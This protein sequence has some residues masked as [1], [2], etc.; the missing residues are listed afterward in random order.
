MT[1]SITIAASHSDMAASPAADAA[2]ATPAACFASAG[3]HTIALVVM[4][5]TKGAVDAPARIVGS[6]DDAEKDDHLSDAETES[7]ADAC[8]SP[9]DS[10]CGFASDSDSEAEVGPWRALG[11]RL[12]RTLDLDDL[13]GMPDADDW[14][15]I[16]SRLSRTLEDIQVDEDLDEASPDADDWRNIGSRLS[17]TLQEL[18]LDEG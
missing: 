1:K 17:S 13:L 12:S 6:F 5:A 9:G 10:A 3:L 15:N 18:Q 14:H 7:T 11:D 8:S 2:D 4:A 16:G